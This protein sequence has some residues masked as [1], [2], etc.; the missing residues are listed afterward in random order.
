[1][2][3]EYDKQQPHINFLVNIT[4]IYTQDSHKKLIILTS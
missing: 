2:N 3:L 4:T 1:M